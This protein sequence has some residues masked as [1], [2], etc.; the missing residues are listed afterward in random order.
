LSSAGFA[1]SLDA[2]D[3][4]W[5]VCEHE[6]LARGVA[7][8]DLFYSLE[9]LRSVAQ[10]ASNRS[11]ATDVL[12]VIPAGVVATAVRVRDEGDGHAASRSVI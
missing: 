6:L 5:I 7:A 4:A 11:K 1:D 9:Q 10:S 8:D 3:V 2:V 12:R